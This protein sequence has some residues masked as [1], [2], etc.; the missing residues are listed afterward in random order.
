MDPILSRCGFRC[1]LC[2]AYRPNV[3]A[4]PENRHLLSDGWQRYF[5]FRIPPEEIVCDGCWATQGRLIDQACPV[6]PCVAGRALE[7]CAACDDY[8]CGRLAE[9]LVDGVEVAARAGAPV[10]P[11]DRERFI[12]PYENKRRLER[13]RSATPG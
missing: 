12:R 11:E 5:G 4:R 6:R 1:D 9:R 3:E 10:P 13:L 8:P 7:N 2:L